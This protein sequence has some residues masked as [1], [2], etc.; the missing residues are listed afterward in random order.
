[1]KPHTHVNFET[2]YTDFAARRCEK[3]GVSYADHADPRQVM[4]SAAVRA[5]VNRRAVKAGHAGGVLGSPDIHG[6]KNYGDDIVASWSDYSN[7]L[8]K[9]T[10]K[11]ARHVETETKFGVDVITETEKARIA[12]D[13]RFEMS[14]ADALVQADEIQRRIDF[15]LP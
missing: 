7:R 13:V 15:A 8:R 6:I 5:E 14:N 11:M 4:T 3:C 2:R 1:M 10:I 9:T 12:R